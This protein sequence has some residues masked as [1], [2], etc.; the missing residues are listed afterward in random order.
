MWL[1]SKSLSAFGRQC[2]LNG[3]KPE[4]VVAFVRG[5]KPPIIVSRYTP[6]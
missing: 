4:F 6:A 3:L 5:L 1:W 2:G